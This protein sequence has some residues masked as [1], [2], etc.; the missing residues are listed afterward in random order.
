VKRLK[1]LVSAF[2]CFPPVRPGADKEESALGTG[3]SILG[4]NLVQQIGRFHE[5]WIITQGRYRKGIE[6][7]LREHPAPQFHFIYLDIPL[8]WKPFWKTPFLQH[9]YYYFWQRLAY[10]RARKLHRRIGFD[11]AHHLTFANDWMPSFIGGKLPVAFIWGPIGGGQKYP[12]QFLREFGWSA[13]L[14]EFGRVSAQ[15]LGRAILP[16]RRRTAKRARAIL[17]CNRETQMTIPARRR[18]KVRFFPVTGASPE[19]LAPVPLKKPD[20]GLFRILTT[21]RLVRYKCFDFALR[22]FALFVRA[23]PGRSSRFEI[24]GQG[25]EGRALRKLV[26]DLGLSDLV[27]FIPWLSRKEVIAKMAA[28][29]AFLFP[30]LREG[31]GIVVIEAMA[32]GTPVVCIDAAGPGFHIQSDW[33]IKIEPGDKDQVIRDLSDALGRLAQDPG[34]RRRLG[35]AAR[36]RAEEFYIWDR[37]GDRL[38]TIYEEVLGRSLKM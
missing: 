37:L 26:G 9:A 11:L 15:W 27:D 3:E 28:A 35:E 36:K 1:V 31:G 7:A 22:A 19:D 8:I 2:A 25:P 30:S 32:S 20:D 23:D 24:I 5:V 34:L 38:L 21:G 16:S 10:G 14:K 17:V 12:P 6:N 4:W 13:R 33:G 18:D 29:D